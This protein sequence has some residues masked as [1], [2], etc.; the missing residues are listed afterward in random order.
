MK[1]F[2]P[3]IFFATF[4]FNLPE[5]LSPSLDSARAGQTLTVANQMPGALYTALRTVLSEEKWV[6]RFG[7]WNIPKKGRTEFVERLM[8]RHLSVKS[9]SRQVV[10]TLFA[11][12]SDF[13]LF[14]QKWLPAR[15]ELPKEV[16]GEF[17]SEVAEGYLDIFP[18]DESGLI[19]F[20]VECVTLEIEQKVT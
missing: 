7:V 10:E 18:P 1:K 12:K 6:E 17:L 2:F 3:L 9:E 15:I 16:E 13:V 5:V 14:L 8:A 11:G 19:H 4:S 20:F